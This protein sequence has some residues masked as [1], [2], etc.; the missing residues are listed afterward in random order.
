VDTWVPRITA[1]LFL[2]LVVYLF[3]VTY[4]LHRSIDNGERDYR[5]TMDTIKGMLPGDGEIL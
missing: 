2:A 4:K 3:L 5:S 1:W